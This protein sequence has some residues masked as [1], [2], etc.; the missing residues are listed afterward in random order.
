MSGVLCWFG[1]LNLASDLQGL[2][3]SKPG[4]DI[5]SVSYLGN[6]WLQ[7][8]LHCLCSLDIL[9]PFI[10]LLDE[11]TLLSHPFRPTMETNVEHLFFNFSILPLFNIW[12]FEG[13]FDQCDRSLGKYHLVWKTMQCLSVYVFGMRLPWRGQ[14]SRGWHLSYFEGRNF[15]I[16][17]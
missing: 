2:K 1:L 8:P 6:Y 16:F 5:V 4:Q 10:V 7:L 17:R 9:Q 14:G 13:P 3:R 12:L 15:I 11:G